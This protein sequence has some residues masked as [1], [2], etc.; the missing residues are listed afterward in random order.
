MVDRAAMQV[1]LRSHAEA[2]GKLPYR[3]RR[4]LELYYGLNGETT[5]RFDQI[6]D[7]FY[8][9]TGRIRQIVDQA[10]RRIQRATGDPHP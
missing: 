4:V 10:T 6:A 8:E 2:L 1:W 7:L 9:S 3:Q 5:H